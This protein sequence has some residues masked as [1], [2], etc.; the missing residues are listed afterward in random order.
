MVWCWPRREDDDNKINIYKEGRR[1]FHTILYMYH[2][3]L[4]C[5]YIRSRGNAAVC[6]LR[7]GRSFCIALTWL[8]RGNA[9]YAMRGRESAG[10]S[11][12]CFI[13]LR[14][15]LLTLFHSVA[16]SYTFIHTIY[17]C[18]MCMYTLYHMY[19]C[20]V[21]LYVFIYMCVHKSRRRLLRHILMFRIILLTY[22]FRRL[23]RCFCV[24]VE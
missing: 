10:V 14:L 15:L 12:R 2:I 8:D 13:I 20:M 16:T 22:N 7:F 23:F 24:W 4:F 19:W 11:C 18:F 21:K 3:S 5:A 1:L 17:L 6:S 9:D